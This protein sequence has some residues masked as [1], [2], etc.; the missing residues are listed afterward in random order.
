MKQYDVY[1][2]NLDPTVGR[3]IKKTRPC[4]IISPDEMKKEARLF[5]ETALQYFKHRGLV[6]VGT[7]GIGGR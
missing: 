1:L 4:I 7:L 5:R 2:A 3:E 6:S